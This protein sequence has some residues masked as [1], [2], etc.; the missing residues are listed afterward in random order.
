P[1]LAAGEHAGARAAP[2]ADYVH[3]EQVVEALHRDLASD[4]ADGADDARWVD[5]DL[6]AGDGAVVAAARGHRADAYPHGLLRGQ[7]PDSLPDDFARDGRAAR[8][9]DADHGALDHVVFHHV[10]EGVADGA[11]A[12]LV[13]ASQE[14]AALAVTI[15][16]GPVDVDDGDGRLGGLLL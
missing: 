10:L 12:D 9:V 15:D 13:L 1:G 3:L 8:R 6:V 16:D 4:H 14:A 5:V 11:A 7:A 2:T